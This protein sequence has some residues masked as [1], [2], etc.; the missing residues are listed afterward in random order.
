[1]VKTGPS[2]RAFYEQRVGMSPRGA[3]EIQKRGK[4]EASWPKKKEAGTLSLPVCPQGW[5]LARLSGKLGH[6]TFVAPE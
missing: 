3:W 1:M 4:G 5:P 6:V 2:G